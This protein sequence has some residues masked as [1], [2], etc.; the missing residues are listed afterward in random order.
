MDHLLSREQ[1][2]NHMALGRHH[3]S[4]VQVRLH[5]TNHIALIDIQSAMIDRR[6]MGREDMMSTRWM[7]WRCVP[8]KDGAPL[9]NALGSR[10]QAVIQRSPNEATHHFGGTVFMT[11]GTRPTETS[12]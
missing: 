2:H 8:M 1:S 10:L 11:E 9:R 12:Q 3:D 4:G 6:S 7:P 5:F